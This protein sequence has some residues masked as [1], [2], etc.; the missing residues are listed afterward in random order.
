MNTK[1]LCAPGKTSGEILDY[2]EQVES[3]ARSY[4]HS[5]PTAIQSGFLAKVTD[6]EGKVY[7]DC[8]AG[9]GTL[10]TGHNHP[11]VVSAMKA[12]LD[13]GYLL[14]GLDIATPIKS[15]F[16]EKLLGCF[17]DPF[18][19]EAKVQ[20]CG[21]TG[22]D[23]VEAALKL[24]KTYTNRTAVVAFQGAYHGMTN[25]A[26]SLTGSLKAKEAIGG[27][28]PYVHFFPYP[29]SYRCPFGVGGKRGAD[30]SLEYL[31]RTLNDPD[32]GMT[33]PAAVVMEVVQGEGGCI[34]AGLDWV[35]GVRR[36]TE[37]LEI[38]LIIDEI[39]TGFGRTGSMFAFEAAEIVPDA[40]L[41]S[42]AVG[43]GLPLSAVVYNRKYD[44]WAPG[45]HAGTFRGN[46][47]AMAAGIATIDLID[48][49]ELVKESKIK[50]EYLMEKL[51]ELATRFPLIG[52]V[53]GRGLMIG[54]EIVDPTKEPD[55]IDSYPAAGHLCSLIR[56]EAFSRGLIVEA[57]GRHNAVLRLLP[58]L[59]IE[60]EELDQVVGILAESL[61]QVMASVNQ[62]VYETLPL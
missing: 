12:F 3:N 40:V 13:A 11:A 38:P 53:R 61:E 60:W 10:A 55:L 34:P 1:Q 19:R 25:G 15:Q 37:R 35:R 21:P 41:V 6:V 2:L 58:P 51:S 56:Q 27:L 50:G 17:S 36:I 47:L 52:E 26:L 46:Q 54:L 31:E 22:A 4:P 8:L 9:A 29:Y 16:T 32:S 24:F 43:G 62:T 7:I 42:K 30:L 20:F 14:H 23:A 49:L 5:I 45:A 44:V 28:M 18:R 59:V 57:G 33:K 48:S 39:Q